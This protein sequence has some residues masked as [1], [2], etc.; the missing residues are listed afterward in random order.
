MIEP[1]V[2]ACFEGLNLKEAK[3]TIEPDPIAVPPK[4]LPQCIQRTDDSHPWALQDMC[5]NLGGFNRFVA[6]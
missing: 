4:P 2:A 1:I 3:L 5:V 6:E